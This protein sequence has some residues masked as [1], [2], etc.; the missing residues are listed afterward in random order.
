MQLLIS[1]T[2]PYARKARVVLREKGLEHRIEEVFLNPHQDPAELLAQNRLGKIPV[3]VRDDGSA[4]YDSPVICEYLDA[5]EAAPALLPATGEARWSVLRAQALA[6]GILDLAVNIVMERARPSAEQSAASIE[7]W[8]GK[9]RRAVGGVGGALTPAS[10][11]LDLGHIACAVALS[12]LEF[13]LPEYDW[14]GDHPELI[15]WHANVTA[16]PSMEA[17][18]PPKA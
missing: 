7:R 9:I 3:L 4:L 1:P 10:G 18:A 17:T 13:R 12:Y 2:S 5:L 16:W 11:A 8:Q 15:D 14:R 6:D